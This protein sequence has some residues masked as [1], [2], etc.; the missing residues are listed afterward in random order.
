MALSGWFVALVLVGAV[1]V[2]VLD[3][4]LGLVVWAGVVVVL[5]TIDLLA[6]GSPRRL[7]F[8]RHVPA[9]MR[10][11]ET[12]PIA[13]LV[14]NT[15]TRTVRGL[16]RDAWEPSAGMSFGGSRPARRSIALPA[17]ERRVLRGTLRPVR[18][19]E[20]RAVH[21]TVRSFGPLRLVARQ[22]SIRVP[23]AVRVLPP[24]ASRRHLPSRLARLRELDGRT[25]VMVRGQG[26]EFDS[27]REYVRGDDVRSIDWRATARRR[28]P[29]TGGATLVVRTWR[30]ERDRRVVIVVDS[31]RT[32]AARIAD[33]PRLDTAFEASLLL[34]A[35][36]TRAGDRVDLLVHDRA[37]RGRV[38]GATGADLLAKMVDAMAPIEPQL[39]ETDWAAVPGLVRQ[40]TTQRALVV[41]L[42]SAQTPGSSRSLLTTLPELARHHT[43]LVASVADPDVVAATA[44]RRDRAEVYRA[45]AAERAV[46]DAARVAAAIRRLGA[47]VVTGSPAELPPA[48]ADAYLALKAAGRL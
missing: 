1:P 27:L 9:R 32:S 23:G 36:A 24:F 48:V 15:G 30:P 37:V 13:L 43:V 33:E 17:G 14:E 29:G 10:L 25:S 40:A 44:E 18:R 6:A 20:R 38:Q 4:W 42:T 8:A 28:D 41:L 11:A 46:L 2:V 5:G 7:R 47:E 21:V 16:L 45:A 39:L 26:T 12:E 34:A 31:G 35:L 22:A 3:G 19:G